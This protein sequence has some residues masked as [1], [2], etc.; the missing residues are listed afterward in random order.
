MS[1]FLRASVL[2]CKEQ[3]GTVHKNWLVFLL[4]ILIIQRGQ[5]SHYNEI[6]N[7]FVISFQRF[8]IYVCDVCKSQWGQ[9]QCCANC[10][11]CGPVLRQCSGVSGSVPDAGVI[12]YPQQSVH[13]GPQVDPSVV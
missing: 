7:I 13:R 5:K 6:Q 11:D 3:S 2:L 12:I 4:F 9:L 1:C 8:R 10:R